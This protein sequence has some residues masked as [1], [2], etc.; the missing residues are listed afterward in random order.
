MENIHRV[1]A[2]EVLIGEK[3]RPGKMPF[4]VFSVRAKV[5]LPE[6]KTFGGILGV[7]TLTALGAFVDLG[8]YSLVIPSQFASK[9]SV[10]SNP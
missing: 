7:K 6:G 1:T 5:Q 4:F 10:P 3:I 8:S 9:E 2:R